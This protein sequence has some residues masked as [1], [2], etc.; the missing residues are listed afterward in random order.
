MA[1]TRSLHVCLYPALCPLVKAELEMRF[2]EEEVKAE[3]EE[4]EVKATK[5]RRGG[6]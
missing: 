2:V 3:F 6:G 5:V 1:W 4:E